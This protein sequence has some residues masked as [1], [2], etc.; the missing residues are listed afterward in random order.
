MDATYKVVSEPPKVM[1]CV[2]G[3]KAIEA[4]QPVETA[5]AESAVVMADKANTTAGCLLTVRRSEDAARNVWNTYQKVQEIL[6]E[7]GLTVRDDRGKRAKTRPIKAVHAE[8][9]INKGLWMRTEKLAA[10]PS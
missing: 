3:C 8:L 7:R 1:A 4:K 5:Y 6:T 2:E 10:I 9:L